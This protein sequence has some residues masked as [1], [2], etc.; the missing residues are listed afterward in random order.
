MVAAGGFIR[1]IRHP[2]LFND[3]DP[4]AAA[5]IHHPG[6]IELQQ[7]GHRGRLIQHMTD[8]QPGLRTL[9]EMRGSVPG[10]NE[11]AAWV[12]QPSSCSSRKMS[13]HEGDGAKEIPDD[14]VASAQSRHTATGWPSRSTTIDT[15]SQVPKSMPSH[16]GDSLAAGAITGQRLL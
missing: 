9:I 1:R 8:L 13:A 6:V 14:A 3:G 10:G 7:I 5:D 11:V 15:T 12:K 16:S 4:G 2:A